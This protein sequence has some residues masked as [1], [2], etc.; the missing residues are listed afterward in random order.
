MQ[1]TSVVGE[2]LR[3]LDASWTRTAL[4]V[5]IWA[6]SSGL[7]AG[8]ELSAATAAIQAQ[9]ESIEVGA[10]VYVVRPDPDPI[11]WDRCAGMAAEDH[12]LAAG[13]SKQDGERAARTAPGTSFR[14]L[15][16]D[17]GT[18]TVWT[19]TTPPLASV[20]VGRAAAEELGLVD[21]SILATSDGAEPV[22]VVDPSP[23]NPSAE[24]AIMIVGAPSGDVDECWIEV[25]PAAVDP[26]DAIATAIGGSTRITALRTQGA[27]TADPAAMFA[28]RPTRLLW[29]PVAATLIVLVW[30]DL[31]LRRADLGLYRALGAPGSAVLLGVQVE[32]WFVSLLATS[33]AIAWTLA[34]AVASG[35]LLDADLMGVA[36]SPP[37]AV[38]FAVMAIGP[39]PAFAIGRRSI[40][41]LLKDR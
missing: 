29:M 3:N 36:V 32:I 33:G 8:A 11:P 24:R 10:H 2:A 15:A 1:P 28:E 23:R 18:V 19:G 41:T 20:Y 4:L 27:L 17:P 35:V 34:V 37:L 14:A 6:G 26:A 30:L 31:W 39:L 16:I 9:E 38:G 5:I 7:L 12:V 40:A 21:G 22:L 13:G 25:D